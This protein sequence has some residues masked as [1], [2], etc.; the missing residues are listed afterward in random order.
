[1]LVLV[2]PSGGALP[3]RAWPEANYTELIRRLIGRGC[4]VAIIGMPED[5]PL[6]RSILAQLDSPQAFD[7][8]GFTRSL[9]ELIV[10][11]HFARLLIT[12]DGGPG[13]FAAATPLK[14]I[15][16]F[17]PET[18]SLYGPTGSNTV[19]IQKPI[20]CAPCLTAYNHR[21]TPCDGDNVC[22]KSITVDEVHAHAERLLTQS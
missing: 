6:A 10:L 16:L 2:Y 9:R 22:L 17:G 1:D 5:R 4:H 21:N 19:C 8:T 7:L 13:Q 11:F 20:A 12:N 18:A 14:T 15:I 3:I